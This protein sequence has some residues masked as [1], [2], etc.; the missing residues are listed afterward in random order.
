[1][2]QAGASSRR[3]LGTVLALLVALAALA[4]TAAAAPSTTAPS[5]D[6]DA[7]TAPAAGL[8]WGAGH[9]TTDDATVRTGR[10]PAGCAV[11]PQLPLLVA[12][13]ACALSATRH[14]IA[15]RAGDRTTAQ[16]RAP[17]AGIG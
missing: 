7:P 4:V 3:L 6:G 15:E 11:V 14:A 5:S 10:G 9:S 12:P 16:G 8:G 17:P 13:A 2:Q 1:V